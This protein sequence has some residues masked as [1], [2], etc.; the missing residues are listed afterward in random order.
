MTQ[1]YKKHLLIYVLYGPIT[2]KYHHALCQTL[3]SLIRYKN[4]YPVVICD[5]KASQFLKTK[6]VKCLILER[7]K[8]HNYSR[9]TEITYIHEIYKYHTLSFRDADS[10]FTA[11]DYEIIE[12]L[13][14]KNENSLLAIRDSRYHVWP[15]MAGLTTIG[16][17]SYNDFIKFINQYIFQ[18]DWFS[19]QNCL[20]EFYESFNKSN[21]VYHWGRGIRYR[22][23]TPL[24]KDMIRRISLTE[25]YPGYWG[26]PLNNP[27]PRPKY[28]LSYY[29][30]PEWM[31]RKKRFLLLLDLNL[32][33]NKL[34]RKIRHDRK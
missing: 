21:P 27:E 8:V 4:V 25:Q 9:F 23:E 3:H 12:I 31:S 15:L 19:D 22:R 20:A 5:K 34:K 13:S 29:P 30:M 26:M 33:F 7:E 11:Q 6:K 1:P 28:N 24:I 18:D 10:S 14:S 17:G 32:I 16:R 2:D